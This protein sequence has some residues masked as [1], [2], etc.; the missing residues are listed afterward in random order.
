MITEI[1]KLL[2]SDI[3]VTN[4]EKLEILKKYTENQLKVKLGVDT[5]PQIFEYVVVSVVLTRFSRLGSE[6]YSSENVGNMSISYLTPTS[7]FEPFIDEINEYKIKTFKEKAIN[8]GYIK[9]Y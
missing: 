9:I 3:K 6:G 2:S 5:I 7:D 1:L 4:E 8:R